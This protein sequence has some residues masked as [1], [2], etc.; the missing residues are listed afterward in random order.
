MPLLLELL[1]SFA[2]PTGAPTNV[3]VIGVTNSSLTLSWGLPQPEDQNGVIRQY[4]VYYWK[5]SRPMTNKVLNFSQLDHGGTISGL[6]P[7]TNYTI[8]VSA[9]TSAGEGVQ[10]KEVTY[11]TAEA[12]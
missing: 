10:S 8:K 3:T 5:Q 2:E 7:Y 4:T 9:S 1:L 11:Q 6:S 12:G